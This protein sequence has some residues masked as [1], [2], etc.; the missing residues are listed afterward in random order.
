LFFFL[1]TLTCFAEEVHIGDATVDFPRLDGYASVAKNTK[2]F[3]ILESVTP[4]SNRLVYVYVVENDA[5]KINHGEVLNLTD[6]I[7]CQSYRPT[8]YE[9][10]TDRQ[11]EQSSQEIVDAVDKSY[12]TMDYDALMDKV[13]D[14]LKKQHHADADLSL[15]KPT[16]I[17]RASFSDGVV[18][19]TLL[20]KLNA[21]TAAGKQSFTVVGRANMIVIKGKML[22]LYAYRRFSGEADVTYVKTT[23]DSLIAGMRAGNN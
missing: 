19:F 22:Y 21:D 12:R 4:A 14:N 7:L 13:A 15:G 11:W 23:S 1:S 5:A 9:T 18:T 20:M 17:E 2:Q 16:V 8:E 3:S 6:Y 10:M